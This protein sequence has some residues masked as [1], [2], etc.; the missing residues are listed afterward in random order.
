MSI[1]ID[2]GVLYAHH[3]TE[4][5]IVALCELRRIDTVLG[6]DTDFDGVVDRIPG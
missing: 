3:D 6:F 1:F 5:V 4:E 2:T